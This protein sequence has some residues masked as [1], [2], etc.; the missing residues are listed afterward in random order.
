MRDAEER[1][2]DAE[3]RM[4]DAVEHPC[5]GE[6]PGGKERGSPRRSQT[7]NRSDPDPKPQQIE[8]DED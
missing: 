6:K 4:R 2:P 5:D 8:G 1:M 3:G 7:R